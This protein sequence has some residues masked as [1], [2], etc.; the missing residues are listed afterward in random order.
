MVCWTM[1]RANSCWT[2]DALINPAIRI[3]LSPDGK[4]V[5]CDTR[6]FNSNMWMLEGFAANRRILTAIWLAVTCHH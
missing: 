3:S 1:Q 4:N 6:R 5:A 2:A